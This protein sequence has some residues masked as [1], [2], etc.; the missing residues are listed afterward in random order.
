MA[1]G[2]GRA[3]ADR[4]NSQQQPEE[5]STIFVVGFPDDMQEREF[6]NMFT[7]SAGFEAAREDSEQGV[8]IIRRSRAPAGPNTR[9][10]GLS[11]Q[12]PGASDPYNL[13]TMN[14]GGVL[15]DGGRDGSMTSWPAAMP[16]QPTD[17]GHF[18]QNNMPMQPPRKQI[19]GFAKF[20]TRQEALD[21]R[22]VLQ[23]RRVDIER[24]SV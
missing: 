8:H 17:D 24:G 18:I 9:P 13:V 23:G 10:S 22:D 14:Q 12:Y 7:F 21:A 20:R 1:R 19:I 6:Q 3:L 4:E 5:I 15:I 16:M 11:M 2:L